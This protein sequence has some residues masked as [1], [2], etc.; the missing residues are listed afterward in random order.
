MPTINLN[1]NASLRYIKEQGEKER[2]ETL[3]YINNQWNNQTT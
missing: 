1:S 2:Q 3:N